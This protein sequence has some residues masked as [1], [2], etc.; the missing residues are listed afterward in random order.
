MKS[1]FPREQRM[2]VVTGMLCLVLILVVLQLW[3]LTATMNAYLGGDQEV[4][5]PAALAS[6]ICFGLCVGLLQYLYALERPVERIHE[7]DTLQLALATGTFAVCFAIFGSTSAM[8]PHIKERL[9]LSPIQVSIALA[10]PVLLGSLGRI[11]LGILSDRFG[12]R[13]VSLGVLVCTILPGI[14][15][16][17]AD[18]YPM[19][20]ACGFFLGVGLASFSAAARWRAV[21]FR[22]GV[23]E[24]PSVSTAWATS[25]NRWPRWEPG[26]CLCNGLSLG[27]LVLRR[28]GLLLAAGILDVCPGSTPPSRRSRQEAAT[29]ATAARAEG[30]GAELLLFPDLRRSGGHGRVS[31]DAADR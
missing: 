4:I 7:G 13:I 14:A 2:L 30:L 17:F 26:D 6:M 27:L 19:L 20:L 24:R 8:M 12:P 21:G 5:W 29:A 16:G 3:L 1:A 10:V 11:P 31:A 23:R 9:G 15:I 25:G 28:A 22:P 18:S